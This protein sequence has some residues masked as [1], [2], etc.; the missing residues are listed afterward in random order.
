[1]ETEI[2]LLM[3]AYSRYVSRAHTAFE[4]FFEVLFALFSI[5][6]G[7]VLSFIDIGI[8]P[9]NLKVFLIVLAV[10]G[11][12]SAFALFIVFAVIY[13]SRKKRALIVKEAKNMH[14]F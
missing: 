6:L 1:L 10:D 4:T 2:Q 7:V 14:S 3:Q 12:F 8:M 13:D 5:T 11:V 9:W